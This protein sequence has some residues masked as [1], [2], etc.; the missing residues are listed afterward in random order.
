[1]AKANI[2]S[3]FAIFNPFRPFP[4]IRG[5][6]LQFLDHEEVLNKTEQIK[7]VLKEIKERKGIEKHFINFGNPKI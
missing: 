5:V 4:F 3:R 1:M 2:K 7:Q 6:R